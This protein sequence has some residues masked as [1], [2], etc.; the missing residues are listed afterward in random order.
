MLHPSMMVSLKG[1]QRALS[2]L[3]L[4][5]GG[6]VRLQ[7]LLGEDFSKGFKTMLER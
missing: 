3:T 2:H 6:E 5:Q 7:A 4:A 1:F